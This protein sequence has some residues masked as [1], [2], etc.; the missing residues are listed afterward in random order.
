MAED[1]RASGDGT[2][3]AAV[4]AW[5]R[6]AQDPS[7]NVLDLVYAGLQRQDDLRLAEQRRIKDLE[8]MRDHYVEMADTAESASLAR[9]RSAI[10]EII[11]LRASYG[12]QLRQA[13]AARINAIRA[14]DVAAV[15]SAADESRQQAATLAAQ[16]ASTS[17]A[18][19]NQVGAAATAATI[20]LGAA[21]DPIQKDIA[22][23]RKA[24]Y[25]AQGQK[26]QV[27]ESRGAADDMQPLVDQ[28]A[29]LVA[30][31]NQSQ[32]RGA[33]VTESREASGARAQSWGPWVAAAGIVAGV[34][35]AVFVK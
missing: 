1:D 2:A 16:V 15:R 23:L 25:E 17:E 5:G 3:G 22:E 34:L 31:Q 24:Q 27:I 6:A 33:Q 28:I 26:T 32:G 11:T 20:A 30:A 18:M 8:E 4:D 29:L 19:R 7:K 35:I 21:L 13:E 14:V 9:D 10:R 12:E